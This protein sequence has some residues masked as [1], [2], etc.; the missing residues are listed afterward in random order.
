MSF[1]RGKLRAHISLLVRQPSLGIAMVATLMRR[2][3]CPSPAGSCI[4][5]ISL[6]VR[7]LS[8]GVAMV[9]TLMHWS[10]CPSPSGSCVGELRYKVIDASG[11][12]SERKKWL[13]FFENVEAIL[14]CASL[15]DYDQMLYEDESVF[16]K[17]NIIL[18]LNIDTFAEKLERSPLV[19]SSTIRLFVIPSPLL[20]FR[21]MA[22]DQP[23]EYGP[24]LVSHMIPPF[25]YSIPLPRT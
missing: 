2:S 5:H 14:F 22:D 17:T 16:V 9:A 19:G 21:G 25:T 13:Y 23:L 18:C 1:T 10:L 15:S 7:Q 4:P 11:Q 24:R 3:L 8:S 12:R 6:L 20:P